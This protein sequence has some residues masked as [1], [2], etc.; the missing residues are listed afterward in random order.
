MQLVR[1]YPYQHQCGKSAVTDSKHMQ[2]ARS[3]VFLIIDQASNRANGVT[4]YLRINPQ[5]GSI[6]VGHI[7]FCAFAAGYYRRH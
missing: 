7:R 5:C 2:C 4:S 3:F 1:P 6:E